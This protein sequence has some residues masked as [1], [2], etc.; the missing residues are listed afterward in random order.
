MRCAGPNIYDLCDI[1]GGNNSECLDCAGKANG[2]GTYDVCDV[3]NGD[4]SH[5]RDC[6][7]V[8]NGA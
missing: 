8:S 7:G 1:C 5:C 4:G 6:Q 3:C 2:A